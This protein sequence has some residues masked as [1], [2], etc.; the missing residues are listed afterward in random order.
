MLK[1]LEDALM[2]KDAD[3]KVIIIRSSGHVFSAGHDLKELVI[4]KCYVT[5]K[6]FFIKKVLLKASIS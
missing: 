4:Y 5:L 2:E 1:C 6:V 3:T